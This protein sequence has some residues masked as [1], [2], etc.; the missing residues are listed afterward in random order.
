MKS[1]E[2]RLYKE[3]KP[4]L[5]HIP[6]SRRSAENL[7]LFNTI[8]FSFLE[9]NQFTICGFIEEKVDYHFPINRY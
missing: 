8:K 5:S 2:F 4:A 1:F 9:F 7:I 6:K 3:Y